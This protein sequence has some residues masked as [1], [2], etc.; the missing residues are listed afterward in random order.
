MKRWIWILIVVAVI[1][2]GYF[3][4]RGLQ[5]R[6]VDAQILDLQ[7]EAVARGPLTATVGATGRV[8]AN[9][10]AF[11]A[12][13]TTGTVEMVNVEVGET[14][15]RDT[16]LA[17]LDRESISPQIIL[18]E[19][20]LVA[21]EKALDDLLESE[22]A[23]AQAQKTLAQ[24]RDALDDAEY[25]WRVRQEGNRA[26]GETIAASEANL[27]LAQQEVDRAQDAYSKF[28][29]R[30]A[31]DPQ[32]A[33]A[34]SNLAAARQ[35]RD[36]ILRNLN[37]YTGYPTELEQ[38]LLDADLALAEAQLLEAERA[39]DRV[40]DGP[41]PDD[42]IATEARIAAAK[43]TLAQAEVR[44]PFNGIIAAVEI[45]P[46]DQAQPGQTAIHL[47]DLS[48][49]VI[50]VDV[51]EVDIN[52]IQVGQE[53]ELRFDAVLDKTYHGEVVDVGLA[54]TYVQGVVNFTVS[55]ELMDADA[56]IRPGLTAAVNIV[57]SQIDDVL[58]IPN[59]AVRVLDGQRIVYIL[60]DGELKPV[61]IT[62]GSSSDFYS[63]VVEGELK[64]GDLIVLNP[65][66]VFDH[67]G[68]PPFVGAGS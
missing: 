48:R 14:V 37:W 67:N 51:S 40:K 24:A 38:A 6:A 61:E 45:K 39:W 19:A 27:V 63:E 33:L 49:L 44:A 1:V 54:G 4:W 31:D 13:K 22:L 5:S 55:V 64:E 46:G 12:F 52:R 36:S 35:K 7:T 30:D 47:L 60:Q 21:A 15:T 65:P 56:A 29:G 9:Q 2:G 62:L 23:R 26:S 25:M 66:L 59:R 53:V 32:R 28:S 58:L 18:A 16:L 8:R 3:G 57:V 34:R 43:A 10:E 42:I 68:P 11:L 17:S 50:D 20:D 41:N